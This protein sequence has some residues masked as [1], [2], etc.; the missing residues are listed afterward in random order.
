MN[1]YGR[2]RWLMSIGLLSYFTIGVVN[3]LAL[4]VEIYPVFSWFLFTHVP[5]EVTEYELAV[6]EFDGQSV[7]PPVLF[8]EAGDMMPDAESMTAH[9]LVQRIGA[10]W[11]SEDLDE[12]QNLMDVFEGS[13]VPVPARFDLVQV[14]YDPLERLR[15]G[16]YEVARLGSVER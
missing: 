6:V 10:A 15:T 12:V 8:R 16:L 5:G 11:D 3:E 1:R 2:L 14:R 7:E 4:D 13:F 9:I